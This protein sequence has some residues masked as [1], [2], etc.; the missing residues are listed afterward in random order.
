MKSSLKRLLRKLGLEVRRYSPAHALDAVFMKTL[1]SHGVNVIFDV[2]ANTGQYGKFLRENGYRGRIVSFEPISSA[3]DTLAETTKADAR[4]DVAPRA[5]IGGSD[6]E[7]EMHISGNSVSSSALEMLPAHLKA[8]P[9]SAYVG[10]ELVRLQKLDT[11]G[12]QYLAPDSRLF[13]KID[14]QGFESQVLCGADDLLKSAI[15]IQL[16]LSLT[17]LY[18]GQTLFYESLSNLDQLG[19]DLWNF[20][21]VFF[22]SQT[23]RLLQGDATFYRRD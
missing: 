9:D 23:E 20:A 21:P 6:G 7:I 14:T 1:L 18:K 11:I 13:L 22:D 16:E 5:A 10:T 17:P 4:W 15:G 12:P 8:A 3:W 19:F 2:G